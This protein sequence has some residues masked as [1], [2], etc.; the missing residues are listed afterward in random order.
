[1]YVPHSEAEQKEMLAAIGLTSLDQLFDVIPDQYRL[2]QPL[3]IPAALS[4][5]ELTRHLKKLAGQN[6][7]AD[8]AVC[9]LGGGCYDHFVPAVVD[10]IAGRTE[11]YTAYTPYQAEASQGTLQT[12]FEFQ[13]MICELT[14]M[15]VSNASMYEAATA[16]TEAALMAIS[17]RGGK[18]LVADS[19]HPEYRETLATYVRNLPYELVTLKTKNGVVD[20]A[21]LTAALSPEIACVVVQSPNF[22]G[23][24]E[25][26]ADITR[27]SHAH[28]A[29]VIQSFDPI[30]LGI[31]KRPGDFDV[32]IAVAEGQS[33]GTPPSYGGP[34]L[35][36]FA[37]KKDF[38]RKIPGRVVGQTVDRN[39]KRCFVLTLQTR[40]QHIRREKAT[41]N[42]CTNQGLLALRAS[43]YLSLC[44]PQGLEEVAKL[45]WNK[46]H[47][48]AEVLA[49]VPGV[50]LH[51]AG[52]FFKE[53]VL[54]LPGPADKYLDAMVAKGF[55]AGVSLGK[56]YEGMEN[57]LLVAVTEKRSKDE[58]DA[59]A[60]AWKEV[61]A[62]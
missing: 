37:C 28:K 53:F 57:C 61:L 56:W 50:K 29:A 22:F 4:E 60:A 31:L 47:Y 33:M 10:H 6:V 58:I 21:D 51:F 19:V 30:S 62:G 41:S 2:K 8:E 11:F 35:G 32:D 34:F 3:N 39:G 48:A 15:D 7:G 18:I 40:E 5:M 24:L 27:E 12:G 26:M 1:M 49:K 14:G 25:P 20:P 52:D 16:T 45:C 13:T 55:H 17:G 36:V 38:V 44:G 54:E 9:F 42:I 43:V 46:A 23:L 59:L